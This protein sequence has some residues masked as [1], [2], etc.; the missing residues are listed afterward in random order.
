MY[1]GAAFVTIELINNVVD[2]LRLP[3]WLPTIVILLLIIGFPI[4]AVLSW[5]FDLTPEGIIK[6]G[7]AKDDLEDRLPSEAERRKL[8][9]S[10]VVISLLII[11]IGFLVYP[12]I[13]NQDTF[14][15]ARN[16]DGKI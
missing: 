14:K 2:P 16:S 13:F 1:A 11:T 5:I 6:T 9:P 10:N 7:A 15:D 4:I 8:R 12:K 3:L